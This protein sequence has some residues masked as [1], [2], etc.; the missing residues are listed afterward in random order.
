MKLKEFI[1]GI[2]DEEKMIYIGTGSAWQ[3][4]GTKAEYEEHF[5]TIEDMIYNNVK[6]KYFNA[7]ARL[8][9]LYREPIPVMSNPIGY[10]HKLIAVAEA[11]YKAKISYDHTKYVYESYLPLKEREIKEEFQPD[12]YLP[13]EVGL[14]V[15]GKEV[16]KFWFKEEFDRFIKD[17]VMPDNKDEE[18]EEED[19]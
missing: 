15:Y 4:I 6:Q 2:D 12:P 16:G 8:K 13:N 11:I 7:G 9:D 14:V 5:Q 1:E 3:F 18:N 19:E 17:G 10:A